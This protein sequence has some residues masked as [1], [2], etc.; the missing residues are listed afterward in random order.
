VYAPGN[1]TRLLPVFVPEP[2][3]AMFAQLGGISLNCVEGQKGRTR[4]RIER[5]LVCMPSEVLFV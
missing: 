5:R 1:L 4:R 2:V 3:T